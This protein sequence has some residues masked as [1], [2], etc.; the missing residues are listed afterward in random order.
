MAKAKPHRDLVLP[1]WNGADIAP[2]SDAPPQA[3]KADRVNYIADLMAGGRY[4][5]R[6]T[7]RALMKIW[8]IGEES[9]LKESAEASR[10]LITPPEQLDALRAELSSTV[11]HIL[12]QAMTVPSK[13]TGLPDYASALKA[14]ELYGRYSGAEVKLTVDDKRIPMKVSIV[15]ADEGEVGPIKGPSSD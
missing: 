6:M 9:L 10:R 14:T 3:N 11:K 5:S 13:I 8:A 15:Y 1:E 2:Y 4:R 7:L 12:Y